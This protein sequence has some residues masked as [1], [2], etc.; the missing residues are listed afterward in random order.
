MKTQYYNATIRNIVYRLRRF[1]ELLPEHLNNLIEKNSD[2]IIDMITE[3]Q[4]YEEGI[5]G[6]NVKISSY[7]PYTERT[8]K[9]KIYKH[10]PVDRVTLKDKGL[11]YKGFYVQTDNEGFIIRSD[12]AKANELEQKYGLAIYRLTN[13]NFTIF[14]REYLR[15]ELQNILRQQLND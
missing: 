8:I 5:T 10:Q 13:S 11:F 9:N 14:M 1:Q 7:A 6:K 12:D 4:L 3:E 15:K 2:V